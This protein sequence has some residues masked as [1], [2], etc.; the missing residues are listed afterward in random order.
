MYTEEQ[1]QQFSRRLGTSECEDRKEN[2]LMDIIGSYRQNIIEGGIMKR[3]IRPI[4]TF[5]VILDF[6]W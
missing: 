6:D 5:S 3:K 4:G 1:N 2:V